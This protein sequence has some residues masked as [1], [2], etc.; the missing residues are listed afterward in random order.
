MMIREDLGRCEN[1]VKLRVKVSISI[2]IL[3]VYLK[4]THITT[5]RDG[6]NSHLVKNRLPLSTNY[7]TSFFLFRF[8]K[9]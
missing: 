4:S 1:C 5:H 8:D 6:V 9:K 2:H 7:Y 3:Y